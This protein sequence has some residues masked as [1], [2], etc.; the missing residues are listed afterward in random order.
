[1]GRGLVEPVDDFRSTNPPSNP[2]LLNTLAEEFVKQGYRLR[3]LIRTIMNS[4]TYQLSAI[5]NA[6]NA[7]DAV[8]HSRTVVRRLSAEQ[9]LDSLSRVTGVPVS[10]NGYPLGLRAAQLPGVRAVRLRDGAP[11]LGDQFLKLFGK[12]PR[13]QTCDC[14]RTEETTLSQAFGLVS[15]PLMNQLLTATTGRLQQLLESP[16]THE[17][18]IDTLFWTTLSRPPSE[19]ELTQTR[20]YIESAED[21]RLALEDVTWAL[22]NSKEFMLRR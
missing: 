14:E 3:P 13:L 5:P 19:T 20:S 18:T 21:R 8:N 7:E 17:A 16:A 12:P 10:F 1:M 15:G 9:L 11:S 22:L 2:A 4:R 6:T